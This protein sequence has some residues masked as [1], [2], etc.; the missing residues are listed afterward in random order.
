[1]AVRA[2]GE[3]TPSEPETSKE[4]D[5]GDK[6]EGEVTPPPHSPPREALPSLKEIFHMQ[7]RSQVEHVSQSRL[8]RD[9]VVEWLTAIASPRASI[10]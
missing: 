2:W 3:D 1:M 7:T 5:E 4:D 6:E 9:W 10:P 8:D